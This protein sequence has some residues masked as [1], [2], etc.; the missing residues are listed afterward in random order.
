MYSQWVKRK[1]KSETYKLEWNTTFN[2][3]FHLRYSFSYEYRTKQNKQQ[4]QTKPT[5]YF[6]L[7]ITFPFKCLCVSAKIPPTFNC[8]V[9][10]QHHSPSQV[11]MA[12]PSSH[13]S[14]GQELLFS[15]CRVCFLSV[16]FYE[17]PCSWLDRQ[18]C[19]NKRGCITESMG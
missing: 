2:L 6:F 14:H 8:V 10:P 5:K 18:H 16:Y 3:C 11:G 15:L 1:R 19:W 7:H 4:K 13:V 12:V 9:F 17:T